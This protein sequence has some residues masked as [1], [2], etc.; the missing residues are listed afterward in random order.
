MATN[1]PDEVP[2]AIYRG[3]F[4]AV[5]FYFVLLIYGQVAAEPLATYAAE[6]VFAVIAIG[7]GTILF[8][9]R[10][11]RVAPR[12]I[13]GAAACLVVGGVLQLTFLFTRVPSLDQASSFAVFAG[14]GLYIYA[15]WIVD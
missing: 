8:L 3:I 13:L 14:I 2:A 5:V 1:G 12:A 10:E 7:V 6:F 15:V 11:V 4:F 9:Q